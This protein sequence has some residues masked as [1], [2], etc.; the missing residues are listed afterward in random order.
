MP[1]H[2]YLYTHLYTQM[3]IHINKNKPFKKKEAIGRTT[4][5]FP[6][7]TWILEIIEASHYLRVIK[8]D[9][10]KQEYTEEENEKPY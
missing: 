7:Q 6:I 9:S 3:H 8:S 5:A 2:V 1:I 4:V 10:C